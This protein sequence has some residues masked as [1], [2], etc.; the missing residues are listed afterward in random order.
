MPPEAVSNPPAQYTELDFE[1]LGVS[2]LDPL[3]A[4]RNFFW[5]G[6]YERLETEA[7]RRV[8]RG[9]LPPCHAFKFGIGNVGMVAQNGIRKVVPDVTTDSQYSQCFIETQS[10]VIEPILF[11]T[12]VVGVIDVEE[13]TKN[14]FS[15]DDARLIKELAD[16]LGPLLAWTS[17]PWAARLRCL[18]RLW[19][20][21]QLYANFDWLGIYRRGEEDPKE[22]VLSAY[23]GEPTEHIRIPVDRGICGAAIREN[24]TLNIPNVRAD[25]RFIAC[26]LK[27]QSELVVPI[28]NSKGD[29][30]A[31][32]DIDSNTPNAF[33]AEKIAAVEAL[34]LELAQ[35][36]ELF[37]PI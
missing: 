21:K 14:G 32:I 37:G 1:T 29:A 31:E 12:K 11:G 3:L 23:F 20:L 6:I 35:I 18:E 36:D 25:P 33:S 28:L 13:S 30:I 26:S 22:L 8:F 2:Y 5:I 17:A 4:R 27:T 9:P 10:E 16:Q 24:R 7:L 34:A 15:S 19:N